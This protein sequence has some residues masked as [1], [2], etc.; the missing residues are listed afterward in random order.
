MAKTLQQAQVPHS[1]KD[2]SIP[3]RTASPHVVERF[4]SPPITHGA[5]LVGSHESR[6]AAQ[7]NSVTHTFGLSLSLTGSTS[8]SRRRS[9]S[10]GQAGLYADSTLYSRSLIETLAVDELGHSSSFHSLGCS[11]TRRLISGNSTTLYG[12]VGFVE[13]SSTSDSCATSGIR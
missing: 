12:F 3:A 2:F 7:S 8:T 6:S 1:V 10:I 11:A 13:E 5:G 4:R 9:S